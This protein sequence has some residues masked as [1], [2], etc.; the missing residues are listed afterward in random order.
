MIAIVE[1]L[2][3]A[4]QSS[5]IEAPAARC[6]QSPT[7]GHIADLDWSNGPFQPVR[8]A[9]TVGS[10]QGVLVRPSGPGT[11]PPAKAGDDDV[12]ARIDGSIAELDETDAGLL[13]CIDG[14]RRAREVVNAWS[15]VESRAA[16]DE[17]KIFMLHSR[18]F[19]RLVERVK[20]F[21]ARGL[22]TVDAGST[23]ARLE[24][25]A[26]QRARE[27][28]IRDAIGR[29]VVTSAPLTPLA[30]DGIELDR[31][32]RE[33]LPF[34]DGERSAAQVVRAWMDVASERHEHFA[35]HSRDYERLV[36]RVA[37]FVE[38]GIAQPAG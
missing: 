35:L 6:E 10:R 8:V 9:D 24:A 36:Q 23:E 30:T 32:D 25:E 31:T 26:A 2:I 15:D 22:A 29:A 19:A 20:G 4:F 14:S 18:T 37:S 27:M 13:A 3:T 28:R 34:L 5:E 7:G 11:C 1:K 21:T 38:R 17:G 12:L 33:M 16:E